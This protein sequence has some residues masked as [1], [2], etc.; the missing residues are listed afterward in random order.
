MTHASAKFMT[1]PMTTPVMLRLGAQPTTLPYQL[2]IMEHFIVYLTTSRGN[3]I[4]IVAV[5]LITAT[6]TL[7]LPKTGSSLG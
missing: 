2:M 6:A 5:Q 3:A 4:T 7:M 1:D